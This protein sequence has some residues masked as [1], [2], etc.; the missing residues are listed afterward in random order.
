M[1]CLVLSL[2]LL[3]ADTYAAG[4]SAPD[5][6]VGQQWSYHTRPQDPQSTLIIGR[7]EELPAFGTVVHIS[8][9]NVNVHGGPDSSAVTHVVH[10]MPVTPEALRQSVIS[11]LG[12][13]PVAE[14]FEDGYRAW[15]QAKGGVF[16]ITV[17]EAVDYIEQS[18][19]KQR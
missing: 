13:A 8:V 12:A 5:F 18:I 19:A 11:H 3:A 6:K 9:I 1:C 17:S 16:T 4:A 14:H 2:Q 7:I 15:Q 10:H